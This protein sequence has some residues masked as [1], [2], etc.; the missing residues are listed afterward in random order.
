MSTSDAPK[1]F[2]DLYTALLNRLRADSGN[3]ATLAQAKQYIGLA[4]MNMHLGY[5]EK[6]PWAERSATILTHDDYATGTV[7]VSIGST[8]VTGVSTLWTTTNSYGVANVR[9]G[10]KIVFAGEQN[11]YEVA[12]VEAAGSLTLAT[13]YIGDAAL[14]AETYVYFEDEY[15]LAADFLKPI[16][17]QTFDT[18][19]E[20]ELISRT[21]FRR[22]FPRVNTVGKSVCAAIFDRAPSGNTTPRRRVRL[23]RP[24]DRTF[25]IPYA[26]V[27]KYLVTSSAGAAQETFSADADEP[28]IPYMYRHGIVLQALSDWYRDKKD[29]ARSG[30]VNAAFTDF[31]LRITADGDI[32]QPRMKIQ[33]RLGSY[34]RAASRPW[35]GSGRGRRYDSGGAFDRLER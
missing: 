7:S 25:M 34:R 2:S 4:L 33:P 20:I 1:T 22:M 28:I 30:E 23:Y 16:D 14:S 27:T 31:I 32:G 26:Y 35:S 24:P 10:G 19:G 12:S 6:F 5:G 21:D 8:T 13:R 11:V 17:V 18:V 15:D 9:A 3:S 29:D